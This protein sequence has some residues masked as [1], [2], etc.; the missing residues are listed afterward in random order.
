MY[1]DMPSKEE[2]SIQIN[3]YIIICFNDKISLLTEVWD[4]Q[5]TQHIFVGEIIVSIQEISFG[6]A[7]FIL[8]I[9]FEKFLLGST[10]P[11][12]RPP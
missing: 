8:L 5:F 11:P 1:N 9:L 7:K 2:G 6:Q 12:P 4:P 3:K 10:P